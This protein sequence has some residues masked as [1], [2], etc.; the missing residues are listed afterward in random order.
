MF[1]SMEIWA[2]EKWEKKMV[3]NTL[4]IYMVIKNDKFKLEYEIQ[5]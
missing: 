1:N 5:S 2:I 3:K 4:K